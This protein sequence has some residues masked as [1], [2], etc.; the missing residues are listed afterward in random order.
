MEGK[1]AGFSIVAILLVLVLFGTIIAGG[2]LLWQHQKIASRSTVA[3]TSSRSTTK[4][5]SSI[6][7]QPQ[8]AGTTSLNIKEWGVYMTLKSTTASLYYFIDPQNPDVAYL[9][10]KTVSDIAPGCAADNI[11]LAAIFRQTPAEHQNAIA[12]PTDTNQ[13]GTIQIGAYWYGFD[14]SHVD[15]TDGS[16]AQQ[17]AVNDAQPNTN[18]ANAFETLAADP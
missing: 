9:S 12:N 10:L 8:L 3:T 5:Q 1:R 11:S 18:L 4:Q 15:C 16:A 2:V 14:H 13:P 6:N 17:S 7:I